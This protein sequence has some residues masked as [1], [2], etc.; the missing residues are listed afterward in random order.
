MCVCV[1]DEFG[2]LKFWHTQIHLHWDI[3]WTQRQWHQSIIM[4]C[5]FPAHKEIGSFANPVQAYY[6]RDYRASSCLLQKKQFPCLIWSL[7]KI[8][9]SVSSLEWKQGVLYGQVKCTYG[10]T[11]NEF[12][13]CKLPMELYSLCSGAPMSWKGQPAIWH[14]NCLGE[15]NL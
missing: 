11:T 7:F 6:I 5:Y 9:I 1:C 8:G 14:F 2:C 10:R 15:S 3:H 13:F 4:S 12:H